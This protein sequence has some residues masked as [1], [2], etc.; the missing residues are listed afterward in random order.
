MNAQDL[1]TGEEVR[2]AVRAGQWRA[3]TSGLVPGVVQ[4]NVV[5]LPGEWAERFAEF[6]RNNP[7]P[8][9]LLE[10]TD[11][12]D[13]TPKRFA[14]HSDLRRDIPLYRVFRDGRAVEQRQDVSALW[15]NDWR[16]F[17]L[18]CSFSFEGAMLARGYPVRHIELSRNVPMY[19]T[20]MQSNPGGGIETKLVVSMRPLPNEIV[21]DVAALTAQYPWAHGAPVHVG[22]PAKLGIRDLMKPDFGD[23]VP[24]YPGETP[25]FWACGVTTQEALA[26]LRA[27]LAVTHAPGHMFVTDITDDMM[28]RDGEWL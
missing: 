22:D 28:R 1:R 13:P 17:L 21:E 20:N 11:V 24:M 12:G 2:M 15:G 19:R 3:P 7:R 16:G 14:P 23:A 18:G 9:P 26:S 10:V 27:P 8:A 25:V 4:A 5:M 6:V